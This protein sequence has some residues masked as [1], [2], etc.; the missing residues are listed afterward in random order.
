MSENPVSSRRAEIALALRAE[1]KT[2]PQ[3]AEVLGVS[4]ANVHYYLNLEKRREYARQYHHDHV[5]ERRIY[6]KKYH[7]Q[8]APVDGP[9]DQRPR[10]ALKRESRA[11]ADLW[12]KLLAGARA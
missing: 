2:Y 9:R 3:I 12:A 8:Y 5:V 6:M 4:R 7:E 1:G 10:L 11:Q